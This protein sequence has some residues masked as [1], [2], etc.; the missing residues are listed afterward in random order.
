MERAEMTEGRKRPESWRD[1]SRSGIVKIRG[2]QSG[3]GQQ[4]VNEVTTPARYVCRDGKRYLFYREYAESG[5]SQQVRLTISEGEVCL[6][7]SGMGHTELTFC[8]GSKRPC[9]YQSPVGP[10]ELVSQ[11]RKIR[12]RESEHHMNL[13]MEYSLYMHE[14]ILSDYAL[15]IE[16]R[17]TTE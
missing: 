16:W 13:K 2:V 15:D 6:K 14:Q 8:K 4:D 11:T 5:A 9:H 3:Y 12:L 17:E 7:K 1:A 10:M